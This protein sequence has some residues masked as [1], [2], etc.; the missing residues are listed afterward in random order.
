M[1][2]NKEVVGVGLGPSNLALAVAA[3]EQVQDHSGWLFLEKQNQCNWHP[4]MLLE[5]ARLQISFLKDLVTMR[6]PQSYFTFV[7]YLKQNNRLDEFINL[8]TF[9]PTRIEFNDYLNWI[10]KN[11][12]PGLVQMNKEVISINPITSAKGIVTDLEI[13]SKDPA[14]N[15]MVIV[16]KNI[17]VAVGGKPNIPKQFARNRNHRIFHS[18]EYLN[19]I[20]AFKQNEKL[21]IGVVGTGQSAAEII[22][23]VSKKFPLSKVYSIQRKSTLKPADNS[24][25]VNEVFF[26]RN[27]DFMYQI[28]NDDKR[29]QQLEEYQNTNY[30]AV[31]IE[32][33]QD[34]YGKMY[35]D[36]LSGHEQI[37]MI[38]NVDIVDVTIGAH[39]KVMLDLINHLN[40]EHISVPPL[41]IVFLATGYDR[42]SIPAFL[43]PIRDYLSYSGKQLVLNRAYKAQTAE[44]FL[45]SLYIQG[46]SEMS[47]GISDSLLSILSVRSGE[48]INSITEQITRQR[49]GVLL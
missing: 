10:C 32:I 1:I 41:D 22:M 33:L 40:D 26:P 28:S 9:N 34:I 3:V 25:F 15:E 16:S 42:T 30:A 17:V 39:E 48:I 11:I 29:L 6:N 24:P 46:L 47:H 5:G 13:H 44:E 18:S 8:S 35:E 4:G 20:T 38:S 49:E 43:E 12:P 37:H 7:N 14:G 2:I 23:H 31:D 19:Q 21:S 36:R 45:P 27:V